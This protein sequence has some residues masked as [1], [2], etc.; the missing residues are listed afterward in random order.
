MRAGSSLI[1]PINSLQ[2][3]KNSLIGCIGYLGRKGLIQL[4]FCYR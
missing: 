3:R 4:L 1:A 2:G